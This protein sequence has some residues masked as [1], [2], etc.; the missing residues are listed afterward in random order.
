MKEN[1]EILEQKAL[2]HDVET[3]EAVL[4][5]LMTYNDKFGFVCVFANVIR[6]GA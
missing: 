4:S 1:K 6:T 3:E 5:G 2:P